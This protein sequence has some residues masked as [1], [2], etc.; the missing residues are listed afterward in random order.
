MGGTGTLGRRQVIVPRTASVMVPQASKSVIMREARSLSA[1]FSLSTS[2][3][4]TVAEKL[5]I[6]C[7]GCT[8]KDFGPRVAL[9]RPEHDC[10]E[11]GMLE[12]REKDS[13]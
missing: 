13:R 4:R 10:L 3:A 1:T 6:R 11:A 5:G 9:K 12:P 2:W 8:P 7:T